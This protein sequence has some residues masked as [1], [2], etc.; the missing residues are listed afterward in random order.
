MSGRLVV[1]AIGFGLAAITTISGAQQ[2][3]NTPIVGMLRPGSIVRNDLSMKAFRQAL[4]EVGYTDGKNIRIEQ[5]FAQDQVDRLPQLA[6]EL[7]DLN[8][9]VIVA[10]NEAS[11]RAAKQATGTISIVMVAYDHD[12]VASGLIQSLSHPGGNITGVFSRQVELPGKRLELLKETLPGLSRVVVFHDA[13]KQSALDNLEQA[14]R[15]L[16]LR[17]QAVSLRSR[18]EFTPAFKTAKKEGAGA[19]V[20]LFSPMLY[21]QRASLAEVAVAEGLP[22]MSQERD[23]VHAGAMMSY[24]P[25]RDAVLARVAYYVDRLLKGAKPSDLPVEQADKFK[26][27]VNLRTAKTLRITIPQSI[28][29]RADEVI[30]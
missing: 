2:P 20:V 25:D 10:T 24:A 22:M 11:V 9:S 26:L 4:S 17:L 13:S 29:L 21:A 16:G 8:V 23:F 5:R 12:P 1:R 19:A 14:A 7:V 6:Q 3:S 15:S 28:L 30:R 27:T 18:D